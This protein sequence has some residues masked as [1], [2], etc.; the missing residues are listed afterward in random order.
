MK[1]HRIEAT[2]INSLYGPNVVDLNDD[3]HGAPLFLVVGKTGAGKSTLLD[4]VSLALFGESPRLHDSRITAADHDALIA[5]DPRRAMSWGTW[6]CRASVVFSKSNRPGEARYLAEWSCERARKQPDGRLKEPVRSISV[7]YDDGKTWTL[8]RSGKRTEDY[9]EAFKE[10][11]GD[12]TRVE[13]ERRILLAQGK[14]AAFVKAAPKVRAEMLEK[15]TN[16]HRFAKVGRVVYERHRTEKELWGAAKTATEAVVAL[17][18]PERAA[19]QA[20][21]VAAQLESERRQN[22]DKRVHAVRSWIK[23]A[24]DVAGLLETARADDERLIA[25]ETGFLA[26]GQALKEHERTARARDVLRLETTAKTAAQAAQK[27]LIA[28]GEAVVL[29]QAAVATAL[30]QDRVAS[31]SYAREQSARARQQPEVEAARGIHALAATA[32]RVL[33]DAQATFAEATTK[34]QAVAAQTQAQALALAERRAELAL[35]STALAAE[36]RG[37]DL[38]PRIAGI[39]ATK[40]G[41]E[42]LVTRRVRAVK[43]AAEAVAT[44]RT[45]R[46]SLAEK[47]ASAEN[48]AR[49]LDAAKR[50]FAERIEAVVNACVDASEA[51]KDSVAAMDERQA[52]EIVTTAQNAWRGTLQNVRVELELSTKRAALRPG[53]PCPVCGSEEHP[54]ESDAGAHDTEARLQREADALIAKLEAV[55]MLLQTLKKARF[56]LDDAK[57]G[58]ATADAVVAVARHAH[59]EA[60]LAVVR[61]REDEAAAR[62][63]ERQRRSELVTALFGE[64]GAGEVTDEQLLLATT[65]A[66]S[67]VLRFEGALLAHKKIEVAVQEQQL[68]VAAADEALAGAQAAFAA[69][70][71]RRDAARLAASE[72]NS[73]AEKT[74]AGRDPNVVQRELDAAVQTAEQA[75]QAAQKAAHEAQRQLGAAAATEAEIKRTWERLKHD[76]AEAS[77]ELARELLRLQLTVEDLESRTLT[78]VRA[79]A[80][81]RT[82]TRLARQRVQLD[83]RMRE[84]V[85]TMQAHQA[86]RA[87][88]A[89]V[90][91]TDEDLRT[92]DDRCAQATT[93]LQAATQAYATR[94]SEV[95]TDD[96]KKERHAQLVLAEQAA[97][98]TYD[99]W[100]QLHRLIGVRKGEAFRDF[101]M[102]LTL[103]LLVDSANTHMSAL[104]DRYR[105]AVSR[106]ADGIATLE[107]AIVDRVQ[108]R[109]MRPL[110]TLSG[111]ETFLVSLALA[112]GLA[113]LSTASIRVHTLL[114]DEGFGTLDP[115][116]L[117][118][119][120][121]V[122]KTLQAD[123][124]QVGIISHVEALREHVPAQV[125]VEKSGNGRSRVTFPRR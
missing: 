115:E 44:E 27:R 75:R 104:S 111:G 68:L 110:S 80:L 108:A 85:A 63:E 20:A 119:A 123:G 47:T 36:S 18:E 121:E 61:T 4:A 113:S 74:L 91:P 88:D 118:T 41:W 60:K 93:A 107:F 12:M 51:A 29:L 31:E 67:A 71:A 14:F 38:Q 42:A 65:A 32:R 45:R 125:L 16:T 84:R 83:E 56:A 39:R 62:Q 28:Q 43:A 106:T 17:S 35:A 40:S 116:T 11:L 37:R 81:L 9:A 6:F 66:E 92:W 100:A 49:R 79:A 72:A 105:L 76:V 50:A 73:E 8:K 69:A 101:A 103:Q 95:H 98:K 124:V 3:L 21:V 15:L 122:L 46:Q 1:L 97:K 53:R 54:A 109:R 112:L 102:S 26:D 30:E 58:A 64:K 87:T 59:E 114:L 90:A 22:D 99:V 19:L 24:L 120:I 94:L 5:T 13:F 2:N 55:G 96:A 70:V 48:N 78:D 89:P 57:G 77:D 33:A 25:E 52:D 23:K 34:H 117:N 82:Q 10:V 86:A 7:S